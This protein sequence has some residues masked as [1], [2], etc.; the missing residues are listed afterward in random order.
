MGPVKIIFTFAGKFYTY[1]HRMCVG[2]KYEVCVRATDKGY[3]SPL[4]Q[5]LARKYDYVEN[6]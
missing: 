5:L 2:D 3:R 4:T 6:T 1:I